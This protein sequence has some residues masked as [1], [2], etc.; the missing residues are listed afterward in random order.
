MRGGTSGSFR[1]ALASMKIS[2]KRRIKKILAGRDLDD[3]LER[4]AALPAVQLVNPLF[5][6]ICHHDPRVHWHAVMAMGPTVARLA[7]ADMEAARVVMRR[8]MWSLNDE[9][10]GIG[11]GAPEAMAEIMVC[12]DRIAAEYAHILVAF[13]RED[14]FFLEHEPLQ[15]GLMWGIGRLGAHRPALLH[16]WNAP[17]YLLPY[18]ESPDPTVQGLAARA[19]GILAARTATPA[20]E[21]LTTSSAPVELYLPET[22]RIT[23]PTVGELAR[24][25]LDRL[26][27]A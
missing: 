11:W 24:Q 4:L 27:T 17:R 5:A 23:T 1:P 14:G 18:L 26:T 8:F 12:H 21:R 3:I 25:A 22:D 20:I 13:M 6:G 10:G 7:D 19:L 2:E 16:Q 15:R 9:S